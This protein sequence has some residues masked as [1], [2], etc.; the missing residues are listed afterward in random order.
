MSKYMR[1]NFV[2]SRVIQNKYFIATY[3]QGFEL[4][5]VAKK[6]WELLDHPTTIEE[7]VNKIA[8]EFDG[9]SDI[10]REDVEEFIENLIN[11]ELI[12]KIS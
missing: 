11:N 5:E 7:I 3:A 12:E 8:E 6:I 10:V 9:N 4:N 2:N 1:S